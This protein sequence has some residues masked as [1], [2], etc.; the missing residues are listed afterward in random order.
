VKN[1]KII[2][3]LLAVI[4]VAWQ[5]QKKLGEVARGDAIRVSG[6]IE[7]TNAELSF[8]I[9]G[10]VTERLV[11]EGDMIKQGQVVA[12]LDSSEYEQELAVSKAAVRKAESV[13]AELRAGSRP[14]EIQQA[15]AVKEKARSWLE[16]LQAGSRP[17]EIASAEAEVEHAR[18]EMENLEREYKRQDELVRDGVSSQEQFDRAKTSFALARARL[19]E[20]EEKLKLVRE[21]PRKEEIEQARQSLQEATERHAMVKE[22]P[23]K[24]VIEQARAQLQQS[25]ASLAL[26]Q[27]RLDYTTLISPF[28][29]TVLSKNIEPGE[30]VSAGTPVV[31]AADLQ[32]IWLRA[33]ISETD[34]GRVKL[35]QKARV[36][37]DTYPGKVYDGKVSF[38]A[39]QAEFTPKNVQ[40]E[41]ERVKLVYRI[42]IVLS[43]PQ[44]ELKPGMPA[45]AEVLTGGEKD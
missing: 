22:G 20:A 3:L 32:D 33:Y 7:V 8:K 34:L 28:S 16:Q 6:N 21:G 26:A 9:P 19:R 39:G 17:Q 13:L 37:A 38:I 2:L 41:K 44:L 27:T 1:K 10:K 5:I 12:R 42:K 31:T 15:F 24:E 14:Q 35:G 11:T 25:Q 45:D 29:G 4:L 23:R 36:T 18:S 43:N 30:F 40:T